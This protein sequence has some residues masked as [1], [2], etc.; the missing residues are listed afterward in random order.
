M[1][2]IPLRGMV[3]YPQLTT[4]L[5][6]GRK[7]SLDSLVKAHSLNSRI[8]LAAQKDGEIEKPRFNDIYGVGTLATIIK[9]KQ[10]PDGTIHALVEGEQRVRIVSIN[11]TESEGYSCRF[12][13]FKNIQPSRRMLET[14]RKT[15]LENVKK[16]FEIKERGDDLAGIMSSLQDLE[17][18]IDTVASCFP[19]QLEE[20]QRILS[21]QNIEARFNYIMKYIKS[22]LEV[23]S[24][25]HRIQQRVR[26]QIDKSQKE[27]YLNEQVKAIRRELGGADDKNE[28]EDLEERAKKKKFSK[29]AA[30][31]FNSEIK[32]L[33]TMPPMSAEATVVRNFLEW[34]L[35]LPWGRKSKS[36]AITISKAERILDKEHYGLKEV[37][38]RIL[39]YLALYHK[40]EKSKAPLIL[41]VG[42]PGVGK[43]SLGNAMAK[44]TGRKLVRF[45]LGGVH[46]EAEIRG[47]RRTYIGSMPG[48]I[49]QKLAKVKVDNPLFLLDEIDKISSDFRG[50]PASALL[51]AL[52]PEQNNSFSDH[53]LEVDYDLSDIMFV[54]TANSLNIPPALLD[55]MEVIRLPGYTDVDKLSIAKRHLI[56]KQLTL[57]G[58]T[59]DSITFSTKVLYE[60]MDKYTREAGVRELERQLSKVM[61]KVVLLESRDKSALP[62]TLTS[63]NLEEFLGVEKYTYTKLPSKLG[64]I[65]Q[66]SGLAWTSVGGDIL[67]IE[68]SVLPGT[69]KLIRTGH[70]GEVMQESIQAAISIMRSRHG[71]LGMPSDFYQKC[72]YHIHVPEGATP[73]DGPSA[74]LAMC[75]ALVS[76]LI[77]QPVRNDV[78]MTG[79]IT[80]RGDVLK[81]GGLKEKLLAAQ[82]SKIKTV[83]IPAEN[84]KELKEISERITAKL[85]VKPVRSIDEALTIAFK[86]LPK[87]LDIKKFGSITTL[88]V[89]SQTGE[90]SSH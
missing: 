54:C 55:R 6:I 51:E 28:I 41:L 47:H 26:E 32:K 8:I 82:R 31:K 24:M 17:R 49:I 59:K 43:T 14:M 83:I 5:Y 22:E 15:L 85:E 29:E 19:L 27:Y 20:S 44:A 40:V 61:R 64:N 18:C 3:V 9:C 1:P 71:A 81:I 10:M 52:D 45:S 86:K 90:I 35:D 79:E 73:K 38:E 46:D 76:C 58:L 78:A 11:K 13:E 68:A 75:I 56:P 74:G 34:I 42:P 23:A 37:K 88:D 89:L 80:L 70:L 50:D 30:D 7:I 67:T 69:G 72:D 48:K 25:D 53:Y 77:G 63:S 87:N 84:E 60:I 62:I 65:G 21:L 33:K 12:R 36:R 39:E 4:S 2:L 16:Y 66:V 57:N